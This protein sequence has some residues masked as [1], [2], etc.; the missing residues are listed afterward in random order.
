MKIETLCSAAKIFIGLINIRLTKKRIPFFVSLQVTKLCNLQCSH[1]FADLS[2]LKEITDFTTEQWKEIIDELYTLGTRWVRIQGG[3]PLIRNDIGELINYIKDKGMVCE[4][5]TN[6]LFVKKKISSLTRL[7]SLCISL[8]GDRKTNDRMRGEGVYD[9]VVESIKLAKSYGMKIR[10]HG[11]LTR[12]SVNS[13]GHIAN[14]CRNIGVQFN[15]AYFSLDDAKQTEDIVLNR[16]EIKDY[17][18][19]YLALKKD[20]YPVSSSYSFINQILNWPQ[21][22][23]ATLDS[24]DFKLLNRLKLIRCLAGHNACFIDSDG[25]LY[26]CPKRWGKGINISGGIRKAWDAAKDLDCISCWTYGDNEAYA[27]M[28]FQPS[29][30]W[31]SFTYFK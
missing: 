1:C 29:A 18:R 4:M 10:V 23:N 3:E 17:Y 6:G 31:N 7:D 14:L 11:V 15:V 16:E 19:R 5:V 13:L 27:I 25:S 8:D 22:K 9:K 12:H 24:G 2:A 21:D 28:G 26:T 30:I 20:G